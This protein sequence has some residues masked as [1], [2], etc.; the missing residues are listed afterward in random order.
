MIIDDDKMIWNIK[1]VEIGTLTTSLRIHRNIIYECYNQIQITFIARQKIILED[2]SEWQRRRIYQHCWITNLYPLL[3]LPNGNV[4]IKNLISQTHSL[5]SL[6]GYDDDDEKAGVVKQKGIRGFF[7][8]ECRTT[9]SI[10]L[11]FLYYRLSLN[12]II[13]HYYQMRTNDCKRLV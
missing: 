3:H 7:T 5:A 13:L 6:F 12:N 8:N 2:E 11:L 1:T 10:H 4:E 9:I